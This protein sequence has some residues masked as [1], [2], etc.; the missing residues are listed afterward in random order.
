MKV[1]AWLYSL[2]HSRGT[3]YAVVEEPS[4][5]ICIGGYDEK[6]R[7][8]QYDS[9]EAYHL[10]NWAEDRGFISNCAEVEIQV[11]RELL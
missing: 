2:K 10:H 8:H 6:G 5:N 7:Y 3:S 9:Y 1:T 11:P 4:A